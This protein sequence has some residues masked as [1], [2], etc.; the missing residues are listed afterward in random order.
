MIKQYTLTVKHLQTSSPNTNSQ[1]LANVT[2]PF[3]D[4][5]L[6]RVKT[7]EVDF[8]VWDLSRIEMPEKE[9]KIRRQ[10]LH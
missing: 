2:E 6:L 5:T 9:E 8:G 7:G 1:L 10:E 4:I 3:P